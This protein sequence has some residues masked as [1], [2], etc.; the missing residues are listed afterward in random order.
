M[1]GLARGYP[2]LE[3]KNHPHPYEHTAG[4][5]TRWLADTPRLGNVEVYLGNSSHFSCLAHPDE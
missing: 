2:S 4:Q 1:V 3:L 5:E